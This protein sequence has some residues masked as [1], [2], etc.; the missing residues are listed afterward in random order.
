[1]A[2][3]KRLAQSTRH[4]IFACLLVLAAVSNL[5]AGWTVTYRNAVPLYA[6]ATP[7]ITELSGVT[8]FGPV[9]GGAER[10]GAVQDDGSGL[11]TFDVTV[12]ADGTLMSAVAANQLNL[13]G[14]LG[15]NDHEGVAYTNP[16]RHSVFVTEERTPDLSEYSLATGNRINTV[17]LPAV[18]DN[19]R[20]NLGLE[21]LARSPDGQT[22]WT[23]NE[24]ALS[25]DGPTSSDT[26]GTYVRLLRM[27]DDGASVTVGPQFA[28]LVDPVHGSD[29]N[30]SGLSDLV[31]L[32]D[33][34]LIAL[35]RSRVDSGLPLNLNRIYQVDVAG[36]T[37][38][39]AAPYVSGLAGESFTV[40]GKT[41]LWSGAVGSII[42]ANLEGLAL[43]PQLASGNWLL[44]GVVDNGGS[45]ANP[46]VSFEL[47]LAGCSLAGD[48]NCN[49]TVG[50]ED[51]KLWRATFGSTLATTADGNGNLIVD[52][53][54]YALW[55]DNFGAS[56]GSGAAA[57]SPSNAQATLPEPTSLVSLCIGV[58]L[59]GRGAGNVARRRLL[60]PILC[61]REAA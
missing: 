3:F 55:R 51:Y 16:A 27:D 15:T 9:G 11:V 43:G 56:L 25:I 37:D 19:V 4:H 38:V 42:G 48:Y 44:L 18:F 49:G 10:F 30:K 32:P 54:D 5:E 13:Q 41:S 28:Y 2:F 29:P 7:G 17:D 58:L 47:S 46:I 31:V 14:G 59:A 6:G 57:G 8:Y 22:M 40:A 35:E 21:S 34:T 45:G 26:H 52:A 50:E 60:E 12:A 39:S 53:A 1:M 20:T 61:H 24:E 33:D 36:A 23:G